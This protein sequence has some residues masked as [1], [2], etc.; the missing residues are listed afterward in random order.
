MLTESFDIYQQYD[1]DKFMT[2]TGFAVDSKYRG[3]G[4][5][6]Q[7]LLSRKP[8][9]EEFGIKVTSTVFTS[10]FSSRIADK[11]GYK[12]DNSIR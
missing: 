12:T 3:R 8:I 10:Q 7:I 9:C 2:S 4:I 6:E 1:V 11:A 5:G